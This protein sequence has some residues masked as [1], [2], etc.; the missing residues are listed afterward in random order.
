MKLSKPSV[1]DDGPVVSVS[2]SLRK[3]LARNVVGILTVRVDEEQGTA[4]IFSFSV[5]PSYRRMGIGRD[6]WTALLNHLR[7]NRGIDKITV[8]PCPCYDLD[9]GKDE[10]SAIITLSELY[11]VYYHL[12]FRP[13][14]ISSQE[15][16]DT[17]SRQ[18]IY[19]QI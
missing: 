13:N 7:N 11:Q 9:E 19:Y 12:G 6:M 8:Y 14:D 17:M 4:Q 16:G 15:F 2:V 1:V 3:K 18:L 5:N 10:A